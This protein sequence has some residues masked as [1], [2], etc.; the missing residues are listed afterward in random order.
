MFRSK[1]ARFIATV[2]TS[3]CLVG[4]TAR[5][6]EPAAARAPVE[7]TAPVET[8]API[9]V[10]VIVMDTTRADR[11]SFLD[12][13]QP[14]TPRLAEYA[15]ESIVFDNAWVPAGWTGPS[16]AS[17]F[18]GQRPVHHGFLQ[19]HR[20]FLS[21]KART[22]AE[23]LRDAGY[24][25]ALLS[26]SPVVSEAFGLAQGFGHAP[27]LG[28][29]HSR[30]LPHCRDAHTRSLDF[31]RAAVRDGVPFH[32]VVNDFEP[33]LPYT[34]PEPYQSRLM[35]AERPAGLIAAA[36]AWDNPTVLGHMLG[37][38]STDGDLM[39]IVPD[40]YDAEIAGVDAEI[41][42][43][44]DTLRA[45]GVLDDTLVVITS[46]HGENLGEHGLW[47]H[48]FSL[49]RTI[50][51]VPLLIRLP[52]GTRGGSVVTDVVRIEDVLPTVLEVCELDI[53]EGLDGTS[54]LGDVEGRV[55]R[56]SYGAQTHVLKTFRSVWPDLDA[57]AFEWSF[58][59][60]VDGPL[61]LIRRSDGHVELFDHRSD[62]GEE[63][64]VADARSEDVARLS[65]LLDE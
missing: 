3:A 43:F 11:C 55:A 63:I 16:H 4:G 34:P 27:Q 47:D 15:R 31:I 18:T 10:L 60:V 9:N 23:L 26:N 17:L 6:S 13:E 1:I 56:A 28:L 25:T 64:N 48:R 8:K 30:E 58:R 39:A 19:P 41:G 52:D 40:L 37:I 29:L 38:L 14:T 7:A 44:L 51:H 12:Y 20:P 5:C 21:T 42:S 36:R 2:A 24:R 54:L 53:P 61:H 65:A 62:P 32:V 22:M 46:D 45:D 49:H 35:R 59:A 57:Q 50:R 33:H